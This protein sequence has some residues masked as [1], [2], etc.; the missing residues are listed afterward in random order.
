MAAHASDWGYSLNRR[1][2]GGKQN[3]IMMMFVGGVALMLDRIL[4]RFCLKVF[5]T[6]IVVKLLTA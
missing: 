4:V 6:Q 5:R 2:K 1:R 3:T